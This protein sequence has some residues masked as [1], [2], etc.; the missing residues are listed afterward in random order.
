MILLYLSMIRLWMDFFHHE[1]SLA[2]TAQACRKLALPTS[3]AE[4]DTCNRLN[5][6]IN[7]IKVNSIIY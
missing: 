6:L 4:V 7:S 1:I 3:Q 2:R 5:Y